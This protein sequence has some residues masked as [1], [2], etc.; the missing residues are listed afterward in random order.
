MLSMLLYHCFPFISLIIIF[1][2]L[3][4][5]RSFTS[6]NDSCWLELGLSGG[7][8]GGVVL[9]GLAFC[10]ATLGD[11]RRREGGIRGTLTLDSTG[12]DTLGV[13]ILGFSFVRGFLC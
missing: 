4:V 13:E 8:G 2:T 10:T 11:D 12:E 5:E 7:G 6:G 9:R 1:P 3:L